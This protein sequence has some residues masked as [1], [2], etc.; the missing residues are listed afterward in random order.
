MSTGGR[1]NPCRNR[2]GL[3]VVRF[4]ESVYGMY[5]NHIHCTMTW[6]SVPPHSDDPGEKLGNPKLQQKT[7]TFASR[8]DLRTLRRPLGRCML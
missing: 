1:S 7:G 8:S 2:P 5:G 3:S 4:V 6:Y